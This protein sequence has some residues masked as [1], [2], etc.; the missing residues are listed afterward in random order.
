M[1]KLSYLLNPPNSMLYDSAIGKGYTKDNIRTIFLN[2][3][4][5]RTSNNVEINLVLPGYTNQNNKNKIRDITSGCCA[6]CGMRINSTSTEVVEHFRPKNAL[7]FKFNDLIPHIPE[8]NKKRIKNFG[9]FKWGSV[10][11]NLLPSCACCNS[12]QGRDGVYIAKK[13]EDG[14]IES[15]FLNRNILFGKDNFF[16]ILLKSK[17]D[18]REGCLY[19][20]KIDNEIPL[21]FNPYEDDPSELFSYRRKPFISN[22][23]YSQGIKII[24]NKNTT[25]INKLKAIVSIN[26]LGLNRASLCHQRYERYTVLLRI[27][28]DYYR[29]L[30]TNNLNLHDWLRV[31]WD[32]ERQFNA[33]TAQLIGFCESEFGSVAIEIGQSFNIYF[34][35]VQVIDTRDFQ[36]VIASF[37][38]LIERYNVPQI[39]NDSADKILK[40]IA[41]KRLVRR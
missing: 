23:H 6:Y 14:K 13:N 21:L 38:V 25:S 31:I 28:E 15:G 32:F 11:T 16:P 8:N 19:V 34:Y 3:T 27:V 30:D 12:G 10:H 20:K 24:P 4:D 2:R 37:K 17:K 18:F 35:N 9:Y 29:L 22:T 33:K 39:M 1:R 7:Y 26:L 36:S 40:R 5:I 41:K